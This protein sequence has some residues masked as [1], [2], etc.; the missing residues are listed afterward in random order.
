MKKRKYLLLT[1]TV[2]TFG[3]CSEKC[4]EPDIQAINAIYFE[5]QNGGE[6]GFSAEE[7]DAVYFVR[8]IPFSEPLIADT[9]IPNGFFPEGEGR[10]LINDTYPFNNS[11]SPYFTVY[12]N[13]VVEPTT[14]YVANIENIELKGEY[15]GDCG[16]F[17]TKKRFTLNG[18]TIDVSGSQEFTPL[19]R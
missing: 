17:N 9:L 10:F 2:L 14:G 18:D 4:E 16:Y 3:A 6:N 7:L 11:Q 15:D 19:T 13:L 1:L 5:L 8:Y 12:G